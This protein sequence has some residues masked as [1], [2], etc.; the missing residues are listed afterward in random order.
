MRANRPLT[1][2]GAENGISRSGRQRDARRALDQNAGVVGKGGKCPLDIVAGVDAQFE[3]HRPHGIGVSLADEADVVGHVTAA[4]DVAPCTAAAEGLARLAIPASRR[5][6]PVREQRTARGGFQV[7]AGCRRHARAEAHSI[8]QNE[9][10]QER[11][12]IS[13]HSLPRGPCP[14]IPSQTFVIGFHI[15]HN[16][17]EG[18]WFYH[19]PV[20]SCTGE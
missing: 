11:V 16:G 19:D 5:K 8:G 12:K 14:H 6:P 13:L 7:Q 2:R 15:C 1:G 9:G 20:A 3:T 17:S 10:R 4:E 18:C